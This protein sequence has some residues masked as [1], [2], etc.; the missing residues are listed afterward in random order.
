MIHNIVHDHHTLIPPERPSDVADFEN[1]PFSE[2]GL[3]GPLALF[4]QNLAPYVQN[5]TEHNSG[6]NF[7]ENITANVTKSTALPTNPT[8]DALEIGKLFF[9]VIGIFINIIEIT[10]FVSKELRRRS[11]IMLAIISACYLSTVLVEVYRFVGMKTKWIYNTICGN[12]FFALYNAQSLAYVVAV[13]VLVLLSYERFEAITRP[14]KYNPTH[15]RKVKD[16]IFFLFTLG[17]GVCYAVL[18]LC[19]TNTIK[20]CHDD[21]SYPF[22]ALQLLIAAGST[23]ILS[24]TTFKIFTTLRRREQNM[25]LLSSTTQL[26]TG[27]TKIIVAIAFLFILTGGIPR[28]LITIYQIWEVSHPKGCTACETAVFVMFLI[29]IINFVSLDSIVYFGYNQQYR[30]KFL[31]LFRCCC[32]K[33]KQSGVRRESFDL[34]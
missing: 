9:C 34:L 25:A 12:I 26:T 7:L 15:C 3:H 18:K 14:L 28:T 6:V 13:F 17:V 16:F 10:I 24:Y 33:R 29:E 23:L 30:R 31:T 32:I 19:K 5:M 27:T 20:K 1:R 11:S 4:V 21:G 2:Y 8:Q 22:L